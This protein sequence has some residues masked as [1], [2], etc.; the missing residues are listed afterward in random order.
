MPPVQLRQARRPYA[1]RRTEH[2][3]DL[4]AH[5]EL[6]REVR[7]YRRLKK[8]EEREDDPPYWAMTRRP[9]PCLVFVL[10]LLLL[11]E[12]GVV[13]IGG[14]SADS[15]RTGADAWM[16]RALLSLG[17]SGIWTLPLGL[18]LILF[19][20][21]AA[22]RRTW[23]VEPGALGLML[24]ES[25]V[26]GVALLGL[27]R[28]VDLGVGVIEQAAGV[29]LQVA[30]QAQGE[31]DPKFS[32]LLISFLGAGIYEEALFRLALVPLLYGAFR[33]TMAPRWASWAMAAATAAFLFALAHHAGSQGEAFTWYAFSFR[34]VAG[35]AFGVLFALR[36][37]AVAVGAHIAYD[38]MVG[39][40]GWHF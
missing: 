35:L 18:A 14:A 9:L 17:M 19:I 1:E 21:Q 30:G 22:D 36:G 23:K 29:T 27:S 3:T 24:A 32:A 4:E 40:F 13:W 15:L 7:E 39:G 2:E 38:V 10:P 8:Q 28:G 20:W 12:V 37:F 16:R 25:L 33:L 11:Y 5:R 26:W 34:W 6:E 31:G